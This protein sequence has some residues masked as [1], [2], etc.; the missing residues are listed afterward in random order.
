MRIGR[1]PPYKKFCDHIERR[2]SLNAF[3][4]AAREGQP[5][6][7]NH[8][9]AEK[10]FRYLSQGVKGSLLELYWLERLGFSLQEHTQDAVL[11]SGDDSVRV[12]FS[13]PVS[14]CGDFYFVSDD[15]VEPYVEAEAGFVEL[16]DKLVSYRE[17]V[18]TRQLYLLPRAFSWKSFSY[19][20]GQHED[21]IDV[22]AV[23]ATCKRW[24]TS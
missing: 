1:V 19:P 15:Y 3:L 17:Q 12:L 9:W 7:F 10:M 13:E 16:L 2:E 11:Q 24:S 4:A 6:E 5:K 23:V 20:D 8:T 18:M 21:R 22:T 14:L